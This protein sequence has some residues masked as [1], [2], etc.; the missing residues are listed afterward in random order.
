MSGDELL[1][2]YQLLQAM[3]DFCE[4][5]RIPYRVVGSM[6][7]IVYGEPRFTNDV[8][9]LVDMT[10]QHITAIEKEFPDPDFYLSTEAIR[11]AIRSRTQFYILHLP[12]GLKLDIIQRADSEFSKLDITH[13]QRLRSEG[14][15][16]AWFAS[17]ENVILMKLRYYR[18]GG[19][20]K[21]LRDVASM[22]VTQGNTIDRDY[23]D[24]WADKLGVDEQWRQIIQ[25]VPFTKP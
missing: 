22:L 2:P 5:E 14:F 1:Q 23:I 9:V 7:S 18:E 11:T 19:S 17:P 8:D 3:A 15:Y 10:E 4:R 21:H 12:S 20:D 6:A 25:K 24:L 13:G 16:D